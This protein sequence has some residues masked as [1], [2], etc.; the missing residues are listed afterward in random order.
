M[1]RADIYEHE[2]G[3]VAILRGAEGFGNLSLQ[4]NC[5]A[6]HLQETGMMTAAV[7]VVLNRVV[8]KLDAALALASKG[9]ASLKDDLLLKHLTFLRQNGYEMSVETQRELVKR[10]AVE[11]G[12][13]RLP[14]AILCAL[15]PWP[16]DGSRTD[17]SD[18]NPFVPD[19]GATS[20]STDAKAAFSLEVLTRSVLLSVIAEGA[21]RLEF[22]GR[23]L[24]LVLQ[25]HRGRRG[26]LRFAVGAGRARP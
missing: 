25:R 7:Q 17:G 21:R 10:R 1:G 3:V 5:Y 16:L 24:A 11:N 22:R 9:I 20:M 23:A 12:S 14:P 8:L 19:L 15:C 18:F 13:R 4:V 2:A 26:E 6:T